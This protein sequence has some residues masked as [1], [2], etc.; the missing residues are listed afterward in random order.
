MGTEVEALGVPGVAQ[1]ELALDVVV[2][3][4]ARWRSLLDHRRAPAPA[5]AVS[6]A[7]ACRHE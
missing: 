2:S 6:R 5:P 1:L 4:P 3:T 7:I